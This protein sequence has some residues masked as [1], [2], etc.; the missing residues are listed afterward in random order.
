M[1]VNY[2]LLI[3]ISL[4][5]AGTCYQLWNI[6]FGLPGKF[7]FNKKIVQL[8]NSDEDWYL[9]QAKTYLKPERK[10]FIF[11]HPPL[12]PLI[13][14]FLLLP[15]KLINNKIPPDWKLSIVSRSISVVAV[16]ISAAIIFLICANA[17]LTGG[18]I[19]ALLFI[20]SP[21]TAWI[22]HDFKGVGLAGAFLLIVIYLTIQAFE[23]GNIKEYFVKIGHF[24]A[25][26]SMSSLQSVLFIHV[27]II[28]YLWNKAFKK[29][30]SYSHKAIYEGKNKQKNTLIA[31]CI[32]TVTVTVTYSF[33]GIFGKPNLIEFARAVYSEMNLKKISNDNITLITNIFV[34]TLYTAIAISIIGLLNIVY[35][36]VR[37]RLLIKKI[38]DIQTV[39]K[40][41]II[42]FFWAISIFTLS[43]I[44]NPFAIPSLIQSIG[45]LNQYAGEDIGI[46]GL[47]P[48]V[49]KKPGILLEFIPSCLGLLCY[50]TGIIAFLYL[51]IKNTKFII[52]ITLCFAI[53]ILTTIFTIQKYPASRYIY[54]NLMMIYI[55]IGIFF[56]TI[57]S[58]GKKW[59]KATIIV[60]SILV[61]YFTFYLSYSY[62]DG[63]TVDNDGRLKAAEWI[64]NNVEK[65]FTI[66]SRGQFQLP[67]TP[68]PLDEIDGYSYVKHEEYPDYCILGGFEHHVMRQYLK[69]SRAGYLYSQK[70]W[71]PAKSGPDYQSIEMYQT[72]MESTSYEYIGSFEPM[73]IKLFNREIRFNLLDDPVAWF[74]RIAHVYKKVR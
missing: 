69:L 62:I 31:I 10:I 44:I 1:K 23:K 8:W 21:L 26:S 33:W 29:E 40:S 22:A 54:F 4:F 58:N 20:G 50:I 45:N 55:F 30:L 11:T 25:L 27:P 43:F 67:R 52:F 57:L 24:L 7:E 64:I 63:L 48:S 66:S 6:D 71:F 68:G 49:E 28:T 56:G 38:I 15:D 14:S 70:D 37:E 18:V 34:K 39:E 60:Y 9:E 16:G 36:I 51:T 32:I 17:N 12:Q 47:Y 13:V 61:I 42:I 53:Y 59:F 2:K 46:F 65:S 41:Y 72:I 5:I 35:L 3:G 74:H 19:A 73:K